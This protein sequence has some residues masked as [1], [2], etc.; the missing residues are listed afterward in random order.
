MK[1]LRLFRLYCQPFKGEKKK[2]L[3]KKKYK[4][5]LHLKKRPLYLHHQ[6]GTAGFE[7]KNG[8]FV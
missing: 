8:P 4:G 5:I 1:N 2:M 6:I 3:K 7:A